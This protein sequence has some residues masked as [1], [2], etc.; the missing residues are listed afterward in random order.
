MPTRFALVVSIT[1][2]DV[3]ARVSVRRRLPHGMMTD[4]VGI[5]VRWSGGT[6]AVARK[7]GTVTEFAEGTLVAGKRVPPAPL[8]AS[9]GRDEVATLQRTA[10]AGWPA[11]QTAQLGGWLLRATEGW[12]LRANSVLPLGDPGM[13][14]EEAMAYVD[15]WYAQ[16]GMPAV[17]SVPSTATE[18]DEALVA[19][20]FTV[21]RN[22]EILVLTGPAIAVPEPV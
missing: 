6:L 21:P 16:R 15:A 17:Y 19:R 20:G 1:P 12:T 13:A 4:A 18:V 2:Q 8:R 9:G 7:D 10:A 11:A 14:L 3:G 5:L 22:A